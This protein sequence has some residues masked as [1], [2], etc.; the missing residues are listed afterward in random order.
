MLI[1][2]TEE[3]ETQAEGEAGSLW[4]PDLGLDPRTLGL[5]PEPKADVQP[6]S[7]PGGLSAIFLKI[8]INEK[9]HKEQNI[10][11]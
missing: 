8:K 3:A 7:H 9:F 1:H 2:E 11:V 6:L 5:R 10:K 4:E